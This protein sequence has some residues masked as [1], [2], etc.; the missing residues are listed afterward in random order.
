MKGDLDQD[1]KRDESTLLYR[2]TL[3]S[4]FFAVEG[5]LTFQRATQ[6]IHHLAF[7]GQNGLLSLR[8]F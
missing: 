4:L 6:G 5:N 7:L 8:I 2:I 3:H 1:A